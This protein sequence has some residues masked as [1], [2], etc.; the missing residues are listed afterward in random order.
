M[1]LWMCKRESK[2]MRNRSERTFFVLYNLCPTLH[3]SLEVTKRWSTVCLCW[4]EIRHLQILIYFLTHSGFF[5]IHYVMFWYNFNYKYEKLENLIQ[6]IILTF[7]RPS[8]YIW[9]PPVGHKAN[10]IAVYGSQWYILIGINKAV[11]PFGKI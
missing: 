3:C 9:S 8:Y 6:F 2:W 7:K 4:H 11:Q 1:C 5:P 10:N